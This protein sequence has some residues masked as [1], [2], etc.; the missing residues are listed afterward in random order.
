MWHFIELNRLF[1]YLLGFTVFNIVDQYIE[2]VKNAPKLM[3]LEL[4]NKAYQVEVMDMQ[5]EQNPGANLLSMVQGF[6]DEP[7]EGDDQIEIDLT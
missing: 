3:E 1:F 7:E 5:N 6:G 4:L 2:Y